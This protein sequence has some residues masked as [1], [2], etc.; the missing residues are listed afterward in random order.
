VIFTSLAVAIFASGCGSTVHRTPPNPGP[1]ASQAEQVISD[2]VAGDDQAIWA[3]TDPTVRSKVSVSQIANGWQLYQE[4]FGS[5]RSHGSPE[6]IPVGSLDV[7]Q[8]PMRMAKGTEEARVTFE[9]NGALV[10][11]QLLKAGAPP[12]AAL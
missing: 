8:I 1:F 10:G 9:Q 11:L 6:L 12:P 4:K 2:L 3:M 7:E 5:Y